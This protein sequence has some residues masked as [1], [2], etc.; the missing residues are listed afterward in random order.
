[1]L[2]VIMVCVTCL[3]VMRMLVDGVL[4]SAGTVERVLA[5]RHCDSG[6]ALHGQPRDQKDQNEATDKAHMVIVLHQF[7]VTM[8]ALQSGKDGTDRIRIH[9]FLRAPGSRDRSSS[10]HNNAGDV[11]C[12]E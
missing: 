9:L 6:P 10:R 11:K 5:K 4:R 3:E 7:E 8:C 2:M 1:M 12:G